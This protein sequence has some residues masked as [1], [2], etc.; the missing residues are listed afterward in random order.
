MS[1]PILQDTNT[2]YWD[3]VLTR[4]KVMHARRILRDAYDEMRRRQAAISQACPQSHGVI[5]DATITADLD[6]PALT[7]RVVEWDS[8]MSLHDEL[9]FLCK[10]SAS[11]ALSA[12][13]GRYSPVL[14]TELARDDL[15]LVV[16]ELQNDD[17]VCNARLDARRG[18]L[19]PAVED[20]GD[21][22]SD[23]VEAEARGGM[24]RGEARFSFEVPLQEKV[25][26]WHDKYR[27]R[28]PKYFNRVHTGYEW[29]KYNQTHFDHDNP[30]PKMVQGYKFNIF[31]PDLV[32]R[33]KTP[34]YSL[35]PDPTG[36]VDTC[37]LRFRGG[38]PYEDIAFKVV[39]QEWETSHKRGFRCRFERG[40]LQLYFNFKRHRYRR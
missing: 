19:R 22:M 23:L 3:A 13:D 25:E 10:R 34:S 24:A 31:Y 14:L 30:P 4:L 36:A 21:K 28:K 40:I 20:Y 26:W 37:L 9:G 35:S 12:T 15:G 39:N 38:A 7:K 2:D 8:E 6:N 5:V 29:N 32:D 17:L 27:P 16:D 1:R 18:P 11:S 33:S